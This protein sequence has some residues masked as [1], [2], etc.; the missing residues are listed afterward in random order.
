MPQAQD[1]FNLIIVNLFSRCRKTQKIFDACMVDN[2]NLERPPFG[3]FC[4]VK[5]HDSKRP[6]PEEP[7]IAVYADTPA[8]LP[9][10]EPLPPA[11]YGSRAG[12]L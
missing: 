8:K 6:K 12:H 2:L 3:Y 10:G 7:K 5:I 1:E 11:R 9:P 4:E